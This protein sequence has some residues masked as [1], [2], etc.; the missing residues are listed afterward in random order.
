[1]ERR[2]TRAA[3]DRRAEA[4][5]AFF[6]IGTR[7]SYDIFHAKVIK[8]LTEIALRKVCFVVHFIV[9]LE[10]L[11]SIHYRRYGCL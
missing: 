9:V 4:A 8:D 3:R 10:E 5:S 6:G 11:S 2:G 7:N 1:V